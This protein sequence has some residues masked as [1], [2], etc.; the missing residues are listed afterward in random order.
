MYK[1]PKHQRGTIIRLSEL[2]G[3][4]IETKVARILNN[5]EPIK[6]GAPAIYTERKDGVISAYNIKTDR[7][8]VATDAMDVVTRTAIAKRQGKGEEP[9]VIEMKTDGKPESIQ[10][11]EQL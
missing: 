3:E 5:K 9:K 2:E 7:W 6:D 10:G 4:T 8:E 11:T 1:T